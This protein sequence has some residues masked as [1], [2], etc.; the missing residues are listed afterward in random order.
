[1]STVAIR[2]A[3][4]Y[5]KRVITVAEIEAAIEKLPPKEVA[6]LAA[7]LDEYQQMVN[8]SAEIFSMYDKEE[9]Q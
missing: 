5:Y 2:T 8:A 6:A 3:A 9:T 1:M 4:R 7:W